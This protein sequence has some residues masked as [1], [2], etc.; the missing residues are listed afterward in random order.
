MQSADGRRRSVKAWQQ[1]SSPRPALMCQL[2]GPP[3]GTR[4]PWE[5]LSPPV[6]HASCWR[7]PNGQTGAALGVAARPSSS[8]SSSARAGNGRAC[9]CPPASQCRRGRRGRGPRSSRESLPPASRGGA[10]RGR[11]PVLCHRHRQEARSAA[12]PAWAPAVVPYLPICS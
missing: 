4:H 1:R 2:P 3:G 7:V 9:H 10:R 11:P 5:S 12:A 8:S 6:E